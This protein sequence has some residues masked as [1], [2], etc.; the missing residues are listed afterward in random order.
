MLT[1]MR[2]TPA[3]ITKLCSAG[4]V[5]FARKDW[6]ATACANGGEVTGVSVEPATSRP[7]RAVAT[8]NARRINAS[9]SATVQSQLAVVSLMHAFIATPPNAFRLRFARHLHVAPCEG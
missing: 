6:F 5:Q 1:R 4:V 9:L 3:G 8:S 7:S 2:V